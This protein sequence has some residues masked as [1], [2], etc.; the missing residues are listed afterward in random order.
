MKN[1]SF[2]MIG[3][4]FIGMIVAPAISAFEVG[5]NCMENG[6]FEAGEVGVIPDEWELKVTG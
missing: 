4:L 6:D 1:I 3:I 5:E 2:A